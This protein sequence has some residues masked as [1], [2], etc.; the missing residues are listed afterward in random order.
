MGLVGLL[1]HGAEEAGELRQVALK[2]RLAEIDVTQHPV[3]RVGEARIGR[4]VEES[5]GVRRE[6]GGGGDGA[7]LFAGEIVE[8]RPLGE[9]RFRADVLHPRGRIAL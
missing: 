8:E 7:G 4:G 2:D 6:M 5:V 3:A 9:A 1:R